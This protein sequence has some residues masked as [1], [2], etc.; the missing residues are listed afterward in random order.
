MT[1]FFGLIELNLMSDLTAG[2]F[3]E[4]MVF[5]SRISRE[6]E[7]GG[8]SAEEEG[9]FSKFGVE[10]AKKVFWTVSGDLAT[11]GG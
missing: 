1:M 8:L 10:G 2:G 3:R 4:E 11:G 6:R 5:S 7:G 9:V